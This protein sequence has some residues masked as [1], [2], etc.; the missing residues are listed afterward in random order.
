MA[1][2]DKSLL[3]KNSPLPAVSSD[4]T[5]H[6]LPYTSGYL[7]QP[8]ASGTPTPNLQPLPEYIGWISFSRLTCMCSAVLAASTGFSQLFSELNGSP[9]TLSAA[10]GTRE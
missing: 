4:L 9:L 7:N 2:P 5:C 3:Q 1:T 8:P 6:Y 10:T